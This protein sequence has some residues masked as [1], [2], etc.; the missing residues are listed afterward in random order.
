[1]VESE[2]SSRPAGWL[3]ERLMEKLWKKKSSFIESK[4]VRQSVPRQSLFAPPLPN[5][6]IFKPIIHQVGLKLAPRLCVLEKGPDKPA[7]I[8]WSQ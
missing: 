8:T 7:L 5:F 4:Q 3:A 6:K 1:M 2:Q